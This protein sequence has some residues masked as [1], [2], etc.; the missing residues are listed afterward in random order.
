[1][2]FLLYC[3]FGYECLTTL[4]DTFLLTLHILLNGLL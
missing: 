2:A 1:M 4:N 3:A